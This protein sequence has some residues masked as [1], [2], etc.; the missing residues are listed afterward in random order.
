MP[1]SAGELQ[2][3]LE[4]LAKPNEGQTVEA[5]REALAQVRADILA[6]VLG[7]EEQALWELRT[8][9]A[10]GHLARDAGDREGAFR[11]L[12]GAVEPLRAADLHTEATAAEDAA[13]KSLVVVED[14]L[15]GEALARRVVAA[16]AVEGDFTTR[17]LA[18]FA[19]AIHAFDLS[20]FAEVLEWVLPDL[21]Q[22]EARGNERLALRL[23]P[24]IAGSYGVNHQWEQA[25][26]MFRDNLAEAQ[27]LGDRSTEMRTWHNLGVVHFRQRKYAEAGTFFHRSA[28]LS[29]V[30][31]STPR[32]W[33]SRCHGYLNAMKAGD[34]EDVEGAL[35]T[36]ENAAEY[37][38]TEA[39]RY[40]RLH[41]LM[42]VYGDPASPHFDAGRA[43]ACCAE[44]FAL[45][46]SK[47]GELTWQ[48]RCLDFYE[49]A[50]E[51]AKARGETA[52]ALELLEKTTAL[53]R[54]DLETRL[55]ARLRHE[56]VSIQLRE[57]QVRAEEEARRATELEQL[58]A[59]IAAQKADLEATNERL[60]HLDTLK[61]ETMGIVA[62]DLRSPLA[63]I[64]SLAEL[65]TG[66]EHLSAEGREYADDIRET[67]EHLINLVAELLEANQID[68]AH[69]TPAAPRVNLTAAV[70]QFVRRAEKAAATR[71]VRLVM[72]LP[73][74]EVHVRMEEDQLLRVVDNLASNAI[75][76]TRD[77]SAVVLAIRTDNGVVRLEVTDHGPGV[78]AAERHR[79]FKKFGTTSVKVTREEGGSTGLG[80]YIVR[81]LLES[82]GGSIAYEDGA[83]G[84]A[85][86]IAAWPRA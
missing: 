78:P 3:R 72:R 49:T 65:I 1:L 46:A 19:R 74:D 55:D 11:L 12:A 63:S 10:E 15:E 56:L 52:W 31:G 2:A 17:V 25:E 24:I 73:E 4:A 9:V 34:F 41:V 43:H 14:S 32:R 26:K 29:E 83:D 27:A 22:A 36:A 81:K 68:S 20:R 76:Y 30:V 40:T 5:R 51:L 77:E 69:D 21:E 75:K 60:Q 58:N 62:H 45:L 59:E 38:K 16:V 70:T 28:D 44:G 47:E 71:G 85:T 64:V 57:T 79:L 33:D 53:M 48:E 6:A 82:V 13:L 54:R 8:Q 35:A 80:L 37:K 67:A 39:N 50:Y 61:N 18:R 42:L 84:G 23:R 7:D 86:F 66:E